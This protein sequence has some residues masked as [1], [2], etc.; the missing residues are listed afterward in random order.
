VSRI[1]FPHLMQGISTVALN[2]VHV[3]VGRGVGSIVSSK[4]E[5]GTQ[6]NRWAAQ[7]SIMQ[8]TESCLI[9]GGME[10]RAV[11]GWNKQWRVHG[12]CA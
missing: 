11:P 10:S 1:G 6:R 7:N 2:R 3:G 4:L 9:W 12:E 8:L 5:G